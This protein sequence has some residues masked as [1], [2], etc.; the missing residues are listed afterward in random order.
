MTEAYL[1]IQGVNKHPNETSVWFFNL[2][3][4]FQI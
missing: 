1:S 3:P 4:Y 2:T